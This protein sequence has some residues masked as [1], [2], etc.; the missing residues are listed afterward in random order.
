M[1]VSMNLSGAAC[2]V[3]GASSGIGRAIALQLAQE[4]ARV[5]AT[6]RDAD[7]LREVAGTTREPFVPAD[8]SDPAEIGRVVAEVG[9]AFGRLDLLVNNAGSGW[10]GPFV[11]IDPDDADRLVR[12][13]L[14]APIR[15]TAAFLPGMLE[16]E[17]G[18]ILNV[19]SIAG[20]VGVRD[21]AVYAAT[22]A[23]LVAFSESL[24]YEVAP[25]GVRVTI[26]SPGVVNTPF[27]ERRGHPYERRS[28]R[29]IAPDRVA[30]A[31]VRAIRRDAPEVFVPAW[32]GWVA[33]LRG[34]APGVYRRLASRY[35]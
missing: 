6:G 17:R 5:F 11:S 12:V 23:A 9:N 26:V 28:P 13:N 24:R 29:P 15:L 3:T 8:L 33:R 1:S 14:L 20:H 32:M 21:E 16:R 2:L 30:R 10:A 25:F 31:A 27:F 34:A 7:A 18:H 22:K 35:G 4:G 19:A